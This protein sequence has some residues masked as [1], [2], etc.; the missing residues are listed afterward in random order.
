MYPFDSWSLYLM[1]AC[2]EL[3]ASALSPLPRPSDLSLS[4][5]PSP[6]LAWLAW[7]AR[8]EEQRGAPAAARF[9]RIGSEQRPRWGKGRPRKRAGGGRAAGVGRRFRARPHAFSDHAQSDGIRIGWRGG[10]LAAALGPVDALA[11]GR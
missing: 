10:A 11:A 9:P 4:L 7:A 8:L 1:H 5:S 2:I 3:S 6:P